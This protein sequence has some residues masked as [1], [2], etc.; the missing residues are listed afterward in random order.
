MSGLLGWAH[1]PHCYYDEEE[2]GSFEMIF[3]LI[4]I[5]K[6]LKF[7]H[8]YF[9]SVL[10]N[11]LLPALSILWYLCYVLNSILLLYDIFDVINITIY[12]ML[13]IVIYS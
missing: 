10:Q 5:H 1:D 2:W 6:K 13:F 3:C 9:S 12:L 11:D 7:K 8:Y 4:L